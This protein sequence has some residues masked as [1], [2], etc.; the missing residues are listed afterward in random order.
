M[1]TNLNEF[2]K[3]SINE[4]KGSYLSGLF[5]DLKKETHN[6]DLSESAAKTLADAVDDLK[7][8][9]KKALKGKGLSGW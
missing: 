8:K 5:F 3:T 4:S 9:F 1:I 6:L 2:K 7:S